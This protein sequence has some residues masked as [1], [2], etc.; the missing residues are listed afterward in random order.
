MLPETFLSRRSASDPMFDMEKNQL[1]SKVPF[2]Q[3][4]LVTERK[5]TQPFIE[6]NIHRFVISHLTDIKPSDFD[7]FVVGSDQ[8]RRMM[9][10]L[11]F[12]STTLA[13]DAFLV[14]TEGWNIKRVSYAASFGVDVPDI[15]ENDLDDCKKAI[16]R[17][18]GIS[19]REESGVAA[20]K[21]YLGVEAKW[22]LDPTML[23]K[24]SD[25]QKLISKTP[26]VGG[27]IIHL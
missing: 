26:T 21:K 4:L 18:N 6:S 24:R 2:L 7:A 14:F 1:I 19:V 10:F 11:G 25:Y 22:V 15:P 13:S 9:Y 3:L 5:F 12:W 23:L 16:A 27:D 17:F 8:I 20:C